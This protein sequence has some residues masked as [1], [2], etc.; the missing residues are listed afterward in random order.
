[1]PILLFC[2]RRPAEFQQQ[3]QKSSISERRTGCCAP[4]RSA[5]PLRRY[6]LLY[7]VWIWMLFIKCIRGFC[8]QITL[9]KLQFSKVI[10]TL[11]LYFVWIEPFYT[12]QEWRLFAKPVDLF[13]QHIL[14]QFKLCGIMLSNSKVRNSL[15]LLSM[16]GTCWFRLYLNHLILWANQAFKWPEHNGSL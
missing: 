8:I 7:S 16:Y 11:P 4:V 3:G 10:T 13:P 15:C 14:Y 2:F 1:M 9:L 6:I 12:K 5:A